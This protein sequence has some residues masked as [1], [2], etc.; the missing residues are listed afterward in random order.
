MV[1]IVGGVSILREILAKPSKTQKGQLRSALIV[2]SYDIIF[3][4]LV[5]KEFGID[6]SIVAT[7]SRAS[8]VEVLEHLVSVLN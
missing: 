8:R 5:A 2:T 6:I 7:K 3:L 1:L 4:N